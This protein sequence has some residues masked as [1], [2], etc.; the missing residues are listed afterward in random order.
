VKEM[1]LVRAEMTKAFMDAEE[2][3]G[4]SSTTWNYTLKQLKSAFFHLERHS[5]AYR[6]HLEMAEL[7]E[8]ETIH[9]QPFTPEQLKAILEASTDDDFIHPIIVTGICTAMRRSDCCR[10]RWESVDLGKDICMVKT[11]KTSSMVAI[12]ILPLL[13][14]VLIKCKRGE[15]EFVFPEQ[16]AMVEQ[17]P[18]DIT[19]RVQ[20]VFE[21]AGFKDIVD[22]DKVEVNGG[23]ENGQKA[24][25]KPSK[26]NIGKHAGGLTIER[27]VGLRRATIRGFHSFRTTWITIALSNNVSM[28]VVQ[29][30]TGHETV[31]IVIKHYFRPGAEQFRAMIFRA[32]PDLL[33]GKGNSKRE[34]MLEILQNMKSS[35]W[36]SDRARLVKMLEAHEGVQNPASGI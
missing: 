14:E 29:M 6:D 1:L 32:M 10:L 24:E 9:H 18:D 19:N 35:T 7:K 11:N 27:K 21:K 31:E 15:S 22:E 16:A 2:E 36:R 28:P 30:V 33:V 12:P 20:R 5:P 13:R 26:S 34:G 3:R 17:N 4:V 8:Q 23:S 25:G